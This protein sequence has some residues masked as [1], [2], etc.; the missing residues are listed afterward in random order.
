[1]QNL[2]AH[3][4][5]QKAIQKTHMNV[6]VKNVGCH[7]ERPTN[8]LLR[9]SAVILIEEMSSLLDMSLRKLYFYF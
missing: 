2:V 8:E 6:Q 1:M 7:K 4:V 5:F 9:L 3:G